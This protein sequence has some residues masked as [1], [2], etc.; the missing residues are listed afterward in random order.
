MK[1]STIARGY[2]LKAS[3][4]K[5][6]KKVQSE[7]NSSQNKVITQAIKL[8]YITIKGTNSKIINGNNI[9]K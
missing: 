3:T 1:N 7:L 5:L 9:N 4:H 8:Y 2:R 6:I